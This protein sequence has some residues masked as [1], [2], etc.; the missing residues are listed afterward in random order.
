MKY[1]HSRSPVIVHADVKSMNF[2]LTPSGVVKITDFGLA[3]SRTE[4]SMR[5]QNRNGTEDASGGYT[6]AWCAPEVLQMSKPNRESDVYSFGVF[7][8]ELLTC[9]RPYEGACN[10]L[11]YD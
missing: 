4:T 1:L 10:A 9:S 3:L 7:L 6:L 8:W 5:I 11:I 2:L